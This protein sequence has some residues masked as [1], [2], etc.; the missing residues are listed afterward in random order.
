MLGGGVRRPFLYLRFLSLL[1]HTS[2]SA[3]GT[4]DGTGDGALCVRTLCWCE[5]PTAPEI[6]S[7]RRTPDGTRNGNLCVRPLCWCG[8]PTALGTAPCASAGGTAD[9]LRSG[10][11]IFL[12][13]SVNLVRL[14]VRPVTEC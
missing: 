9:G 13:V 11:G 8:P 2:A 4:A 6:A 7:P 10:F 5:L 3:G 12:V 14:L 1:M